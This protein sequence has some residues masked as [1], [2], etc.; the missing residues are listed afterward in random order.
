MATWKDLSS[1]LI[2]QIVTH[3][4][5]K[6]VAKPVEEKSFSRFRVMLE[7]RSGGGGGW[8]LPVEIG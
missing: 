2:V 4:T 6:K 3:L 8:P 5:M 7:N 1:S